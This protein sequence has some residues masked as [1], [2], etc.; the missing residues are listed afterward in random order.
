M[1]LSI[2]TATTRRA[3]AFG[4]ISRPVSGE[5]N[6]GGVGVGDGEGVGVGGGVVGVGAGEA[7]AAS[8]GGGRV[9]RG[10]ATV[11][12]GA[13][14]DAGGG[15]IGGEG[16]TVAAGVT[17]DAALAAVS[18]VGA[19]GVDTEGAAG[20]GVGVG[21]AD[22]P[23]AATRRAVPAD[24]RSARRRREM[25]AGLRMRDTR[26]S[27][28]RTDMATGCGGGG[29]GATRVRQGARFPAVRTRRRR[30]RRLNLICCRLG[31]G[32]LGL[33]EGAA[34]GG[35]DARGT[36]GDG[37]GAQVVVK[38]LDAAGALVA[39]GFEGSQDG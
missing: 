16:A 18:D 7:V 20:V 27:G 3:L 1:E 10:A 11:G 32:L 22:S 8:A 23:Q 38:D 28:R 15:G 13:A 2:L 14:V 29:G 12:S 21:D 5:S 31:S 19:G 9:G 26:L 39:H 34:A 25:R 4:L 36:F 30:L 35:G 6:G 33:A 17:G 24:R 37:Q